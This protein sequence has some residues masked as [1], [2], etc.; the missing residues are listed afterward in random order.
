MVEINCE[1]V[2]NFEKSLENN[3]GRL[4]YF[5]YCLWH[6]NC[7]VTINNSAPQAPHLSLQLEASH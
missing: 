3:F 7:V 1:L 6:L 2:S 4:E 5:H